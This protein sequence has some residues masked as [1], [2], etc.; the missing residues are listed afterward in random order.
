MKFKSI[1]IFLFSDIICGSFCFRESAFANQ[2]R[3]TKDEIN[4][5]LKRAFN[6]EEE[7]TDPNVIFELAI[8]DY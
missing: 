4:T 1:I 3:D 7:I 8:E 6:S 2:I 5:T